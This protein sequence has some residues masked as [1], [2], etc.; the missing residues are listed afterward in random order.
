LQTPTIDINEN[1]SHRFS[2][3]VTKARIGGTAGAI[4]KILPKGCN[5]KL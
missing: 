3:Q 4:K 1:T 2:S 5:V